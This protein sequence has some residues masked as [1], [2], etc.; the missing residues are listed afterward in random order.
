MIERLFG[1]LPIDEVKRQE[2]FIDSHGFIYTIQSAESGWTI[3]YSDGC[4]KYKDE[5]NSIDGNF[6]TAKETLIE[7]VGNIEP[8]DLERMAKL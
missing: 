6:N 5:I 3:I 4:T 7:E 8:V 2:H 1:L